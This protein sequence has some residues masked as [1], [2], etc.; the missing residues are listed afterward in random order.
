[1][2]ARQQ[3]QLFPP[4]EPYR[5]GM[6]PV[7]ALH[8]LYWE[9]SGN[10]DG[11]PVVYLHG[12]PGSGAAPQK[13]QWFNPAHYR[14]VLA[15]QRGAFRSTPLGECRANTTQLLVQDL[16]A[17]R[18][19]LC[20]ECWLVTGGSWGALLALAYG[21]AH[22][23][24][25]LGFVLRGIL[26]G[27]LE[28]IDWYLHGMRLFYPRAHERFTAWIPEQERGDLIAAYEK[29]LFGDAPAVRMEVARRW[30]RYSADCALLRHDPQV[31]E[32]ALEQH[33]AVY[34]TARLHVHY[35]RHRM[36]LEPGQLLDDMDRIA[37]L[38]AMLV[39]GGHDVIA[40]PQAA[41]RLHRA[42]PGSVLH[43]VPDAGHAPSE[44]G[45]RARLVQAL[46]QFC[47][48]GKFR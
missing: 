12:G 14:I 8:T 44:A 47:Q 43:V 1:M 24:A 32:K 39:Q 30:C 40:P 10:P 5:T 13:R 28:E 31:V 29:R 46:E 3:F 36:F 6:L 9:E 21:Q 42:W 7:D 11:L 17:L 16:E 23:E 38:P 45:T 26:L 20:I 18:R 4:I 34:S 33:G 22:P 48:E 19:M 37:H 35:F 2:N 27:S 41:Y 15:D 25:C